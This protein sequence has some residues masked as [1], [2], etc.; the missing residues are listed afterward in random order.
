MMS[1]GFKK[2]E[3]GASLETLQGD[4]GKSRGNYKNKRS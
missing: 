4:L 2:R 1:P 3:S